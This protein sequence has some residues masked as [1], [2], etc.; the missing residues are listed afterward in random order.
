MRCSRCR[1]RLSFVAC[2]KYHPSPR[3]RHIHSAVS[4]KSTCTDVHLAVVERQ[5][6]PRNTFSIVS[7]AAQGL[8]HIQ[9]G[10]RPVT[11]QLAD[12]PTRGLDIS[13][14]GQLADAADRSICCFNCMIGLCGH[15]ATNRIAYMPNICLSTHPRKHQ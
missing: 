1:P 12:P 8:N 13:R 9:N 6:R 7:R 10:H 15:N 2:R 14:T 5:M 11:G 3:W 4:C